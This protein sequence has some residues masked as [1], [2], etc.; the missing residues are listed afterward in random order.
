MDKTQKK[1]RWTQLTCGFIIYIILQWI[2]FKIWITL[3]QENGDLSRLL[4][5][6]QVVNEDD[7]VI[8]IY[9]RIPK[10]G[11]TSFMHLPYELCDENKFNVLLLNI[12]NPHSMTFSDR[13][14][15]AN[16]V[17]H[18]YEKMPALYHGHFAY[19]D[20]Q[21]MGVQTGNVKFIN[22]N[23]VRQP[24]ERLVSY[25][26]FLRYGDDYRKGK[27][28]SHMGDKTTFDECVAKKLRDCDPK[29][30]WQ[31]VPW[32]CGHFRRCWDPPGNRWALEQAKFNLANKYFL[33]GLTEDLE[34][35]IDLMEMSLPRFF[36]GAGLLF[37]SSYETSHIRRTIHKDSVSQ[38]TIDAFKDT[39]IWKAEMEFYEFARSHF[40]VI[41]NELTAA[42][43]GGAN[44]RIYH[45]EKTRP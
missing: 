27:I 25:Y 28:R 31:Q 39:R 5:S 24:L 20:V 16:N 12:S 41:K 26:Y 17:S 45:Y 4:P 10:T 6:K 8:V 2:S 9:N 34:T 38:K 32:F 13:I 7:K 23:I 21:N 36:K 30:L 11:S 1:M 3:N 15:F 33:V 18:W 35:F 19:F 29:K 44:K 22:I 43:N 40:D 37:R 42:E 14:F